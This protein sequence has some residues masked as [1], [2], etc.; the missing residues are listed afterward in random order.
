[1][2][3]AQDERGTEPACARWLHVKW[4]LG[5]GQGLE[6]APPPFELCV[7]DAGSNAPGIHQPAA[8]VVVGEQQRTDPGPG[9][10]GIRPADYHDLL[11][12]QTFD[13]EPQAAIARGIGR[14]LSRDPLPRARPS[15]NPGK[16]EPC[17]TSG[18]RIAC[19]RRVQTII[20]GEGCRTKLVNGKRCAYARRTAFED[21]IDGSR[22][23]AQ[24]AG[25]PLRGPQ[26]YHAT[27][28]GRGCRCAGPW[29]SRK[30][31]TQRGRPLRL[32][33]D[34]RPFRSIRFSETGIA[35]YNAANAQ[36]G[37]DILV[38]MEMAACV[39]RRRGGSGYRGLSVLNRSDT[40]VNHQSEAALQ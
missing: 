36:C 29:D 15:G 30:L 16:V 33:G 26:V 34:P 1:M 11:A 21:V 28:L 3:A 17:S 14:T 24:V 8:R 40:R 19:Q 23:R 27:D 38:E 20:A 39:R 37:C 4:Y 25:N 2:D 31:D 6:A 12:V 9:A 5:H 10:F 13:L 22:N 7:V 35:W 18:L 32:K